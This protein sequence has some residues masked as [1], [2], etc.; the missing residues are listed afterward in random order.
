MRAKALESGAFSITDSKDS[1]TLS[2]KRWFRTKIATVCATPKRITIFRGE[3][4]ELL[5]KWAEEYTK[6]CPEAAV[7]ITSG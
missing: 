6:T 5:T 2:S 3:Y 4:A 1:I 7:I